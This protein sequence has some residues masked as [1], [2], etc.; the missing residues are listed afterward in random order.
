MY[1]ESFYY[2]A[3]VSLNDNHIAGYPIVCECED[4]GDGI[5]QGQEYISYDGQPI[6]LNCVE[7]ADDE[8]ARE[9]TDCGEYEHGGKFLLGQFVCS[10]C[11]ERMRK[12]AGDD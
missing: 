12:V 9:C 2:P 11:F 8:V 10:A 6:C 3:G 1:R 7:N 5:E 4:C